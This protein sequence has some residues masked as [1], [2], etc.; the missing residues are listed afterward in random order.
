MIK[1]PVINYIRWFEEISIHDTALVG[2]KTASLGEM[3][4]NLNPQ[5]IAIP[6][7]FGITTEAYRLFLEKNDLEAYIRNKLEQADLNDP[8]QLQEVGR[9][10]RHMLI[11]AR[12]PS[13]LEEQMLNAYRKLS[14]KQVLP[15]LAIRSSASAEDLPEASFAG[16]QETYLN[17]RTE[18]LFLSTCKQCFASLFTDR[19]ISYREERHY[20]HLAV[21]LSICVQHMVRSDMASS[22]VMFSIDTESGFKNAVLINAG[23]GLGENI[24]QGTITPDEFFVFKPTLL[25]GKKPILQKYLGSKEYKLIYDMGGNKLVK[26]VPV[27]QVERQK[28]SISDDEILKLAKWACA[29]ENYYTQLRG[30]P[31]PMD[32]EWAKD[33]LSGQLFIVQARPETVHSQKSE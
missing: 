32:M 10:I 1:T 30:T 9:T 3:Y 12:I 4:R 27:S 15:S 26:N 28:F 16:Q 29:I 6:Y 21:A 2:G 11:D 7:G 18:S 24:V 13:G 33:G 17:V 25:E 20:D 23:Y 14:A 22:G 8:G 19:A 5:G 31:T